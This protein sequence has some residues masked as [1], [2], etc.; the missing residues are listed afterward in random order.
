MVDICLIGT[1]G[2]MPLKDRW[3]TGLFVEV[4]GNAALIDCGEG[5]QIALSCSHLHISRIRMIVITHIHADHIA[6]LPGLLLSIGNS[7]RTE[8]VDI[9]A[10]KGSLKVLAGLLSV[11]GGLPYDVL[12]HE[13][14][15][16]NCGKF[17]ENVICPNSEFSYMPLRH[18]I[19]CLG[20]SFILKRKPVFDPNTADRLGVP[21]NMRS[22]LHN[23]EAVT[24]EDG[25][26]I[27]PQDVISA[28]RE[29]IKITYT[30]D[31]LPFEELSA[32]AKNSDL[33]V[34][35]GMYGDTD[36]KESMN[37]K[38]HMLMQDACRLAVDAD[39]KRLW[40]TH[41]SPAMTCPQDYEETLKNIFPNTVISVDG[42]RISL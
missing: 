22:R 13:L 28:P 1:G 32:F 5:A 36:K 38:R 24:L 39:V 27:L 41:Y 14:D 10:P 21:V 19:D 25:R 9:Y 4:N 15:T 16:E 29:P 20:Y 42:E 26:V 40:L 35:E 37:K 34:C 12:L 6:G 31:T 23:G 11:C 7:A 30:T 2:M 18:R 3:L 33:F 8:P 17:G